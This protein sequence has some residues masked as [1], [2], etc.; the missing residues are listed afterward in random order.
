[1]EWDG[2]D[3]REYDRLTGVAIPGNFKSFL[4]DQGNGELVK[5]ETTDFSVKGVRLLIPL[6]NTNFNSGDG[7]ILVPE[8]RKFKLVGEIIHS[9]KIDENTCYA[10]IKFLKTKSLDEYLMCIK[11]LNT[12]RIEA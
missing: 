11:D 7:V 6:A 8:D 5:A 4:I 3:M 12:R 1:M 9:V 2:E 10:G